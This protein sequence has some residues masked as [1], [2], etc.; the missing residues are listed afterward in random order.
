MSHCR[1][2]RRLCSDIIF[3]TLSGRVYQAGTIVVGNQ[4][5][6][7]GELLGILWL[8]GPYFEYSHLLGV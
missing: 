1:P 3:D 2:V 4:T 8:L 6:G 5:G 7:Y